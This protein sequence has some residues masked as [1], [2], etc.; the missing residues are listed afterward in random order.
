MD[1]YT[2]SSTGDGL[3]L[4]DMI[5]CDIRSNYSENVPTDHGDVL[6]SQGSGAELPS[7]GG[8]MTLDAFASAATTSEAGLTGMTNL[9]DVTKFTWVPALNLSH[10]QNYNP[11][12]NSD[13]NL[14]VDPQTG[15]PVSQAELQQT[16]NA[17]AASQ[18]LT[19]VNASVNAITTSAQ[20]GLLQTAHGQFITIPAHL[21]RAY[22]QQQQQPPSPVQPSSPLRQ[23]L[24][25]IPAQQTQPHSPV[26]VNTT[27]YILANNTIQTLPQSPSHKVA[28]KVSRTE[29]AP[30]KTYPKPVY[31][32]SCLIAMALKNSETG[33]LPVSEIYSF[34]T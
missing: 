19:Q 22:L 32:Y 21:Q 5:E 8:A 28:H 34:M 25:G 6:G 33:C 29:E 10:L 1:F 2:G 14:M 15:V 4:Q 9:T 11:T 27:A 7:P 20:T 18:T 3:S 16:I 31:S 24:Q 17:V 30:S 23:H 13:P 26:R 12:E